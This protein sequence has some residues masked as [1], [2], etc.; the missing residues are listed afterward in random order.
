MRKILMIA[1]LLAVT[2]RRVF[3]TQTHDAPQLCAFFA[4]VHHA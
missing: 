3:T 4:M 1:L 2:L